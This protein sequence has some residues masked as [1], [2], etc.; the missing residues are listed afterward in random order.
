M[1]I[2]GR[3]DRTRRGHECQNVVTDHNIN[4]D[5]SRTDAKRESRAFLYARRAEERHAE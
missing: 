2:P 4:Y 1:G 3:C 5:A